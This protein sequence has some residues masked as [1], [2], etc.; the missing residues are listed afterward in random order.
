MKTDPLVIERQ[1]HARLKFM[2]VILLFCALCALAWDFLPTVDDEI[3]ALLLEMEEAPPPISPYLASS[4]FAIVGVAC[5]L[6]YWR[7]KKTL[8]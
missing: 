7:K 5:F 1:L 6:V 4:S 3:E 2:G 8:S